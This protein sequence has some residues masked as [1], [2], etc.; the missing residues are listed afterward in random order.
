MSHIS[1]QMWEAMNRIRN[2]TIP[3]EQVYCFLSSLGVNLAQVY[4]NS[5]DPPLWAF[6]HGANENSFTAQQLQRFMDDPDGVLPILQFEASRKLVGL[7]PVSYGDV[8]DFQ[9]VD[10]KPLYRAS[11]HEGNVV[12][13]G[14]REGKVH[15]LV[16]ELEFADGQPL[17]K[18]QNVRDQIY[19]VHGDRR[20]G[21]Y[22]DIDGLTTYEGKPLFFGE[23]G[24]EKIVVV[25]GEDV[26]G[27]YDRIDGLLPEFQFAAGRA[28]FGAERDDKWYVVWGSREFGP[29]EQ[30]D[31]ITVCDE[32]P[33]F[34]AKR[35][36]MYFIVWGDEEFGGYDGGIGDEKVI[37]GVPVYCAKHHGKEF[38]VVGKKEGRR[39][40]RVYNPI[41][42]NGV[43]IYSVEQGD[44]MFIVRGDEEIGGHRRA[45]DP[46]IH[47]GALW[48]HAAN[49]DG[50]HFL[51]RDGEEQKHYKY[52]SR[53]MFMN[54]KPLY[55]IDV[56]GGQD[57]LIVWGDEEFGPYKKLSDITS[58]SV[59]IVD[60]KPLFLAGTHYGI[61]SAIWGKSE[62]GQFDSVC[63]LQVTDTE[64]SFGARKG[65]RLYRVSISRE[66]ATK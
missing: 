36:K 6:M 50:E 43:L 30:V 58:I 1:R 42:V 45:Y 24:D 47:E 2:G 57:R 21:P 7:V 52:F 38:V 17:Y 55:Q 53:F 23:R 39:Y 60:G 3:P 27:C 14:E 20:Y 44:R 46:V 8:K 19:A 12:V 11:C 56:H 66:N 28:V 40:D 10:G 18:A 31:D 61:Y 49:G 5:N 37:D 65:R 9:L 63:S 16:W 48:F 35:G 4:K 51:V 32:K 33:F 59:S 34:C 25:W 64:I 26:F 41:I 13:F 29:Y 62:F 22:V 15:Q 54:G